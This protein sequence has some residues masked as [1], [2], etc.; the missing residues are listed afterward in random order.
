LAFIGP[1][2]WLQAFANGKFVK[3]TS[4]LINGYSVSYNVICINTTI[5]KVKIYYKGKV[6][7][8]N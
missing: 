7:D 5:D 3:V 1:N 4:D 2:G 8:T 6:Y